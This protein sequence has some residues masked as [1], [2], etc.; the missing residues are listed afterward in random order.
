MRLADAIGEVTKT[1]EGVMAA[2][3]EKGGDE[4]RRKL[5]RKARRLKKRKRLCQARMELHAVE[6]EIVSESHS[7]DNSDGN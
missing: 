6:R 1:L 5:K 4:A 2:L 7:D 3:N